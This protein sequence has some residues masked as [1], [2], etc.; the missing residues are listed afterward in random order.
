MTARRT[1][2]LEPESDGVH[3]RVLFVPGTNFKVLGLI[4]P[5]GEETRGRLLLR[6]L[7]AL[8]VDNDGRVDP[9]RISLDE[10]AL[11]S[12]QRQF[13]KWAGQATAQ[14]APAM[15]ARFSMLPGLSQE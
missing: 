1:R 2:L 9:N 8:E 3:E 14:V 4:E 11:Q 6:E 13:E 7:T 10:L 15:A 5:Q 12:L